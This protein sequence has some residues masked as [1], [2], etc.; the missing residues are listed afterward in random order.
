MA[1]VKTGHWTETSWNTAGV[2]P[3]C[4]ARGCNRGPSVSNR[5][6][7]IRLQRR[8]FSREDVHRVSREGTRDGSGYSTRP[9]FCLD[10]ANG[11][12]D[13]GYEQNRVRKS[14]CRSQCERPRVGLGPILDCAPL[15][16]ALSLSGRGRPVSDCRRRHFV[17]KSRGNAYHIRDLLAPVLQ[18]SSLAIV[19]S[20]RQSTWQYHR[21]RC[22]HFDSQ[23]CWT[24][25]EDE[26]GFK[27]HTQSGH[28]LRQI[29]S[30][31]G[32]LADTWPTF[33]ASFDMTLSNALLGGT[34]HPSLCMSSHLDVA[35]MH[36]WHETKGNQL[37]QRLCRVLLR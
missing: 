5:P 6:A 12:I 23:V 9:T 31:V 24:Q 8:A 16:F 4:S 36:I 34:F 32:T 27:C 2:P 14:R 20:E 17:S 1:G 22:R 33:R 10:I 15:P 26:H 35:T 18:H 19:Q 21:R 25:H 29:G 30:L 37:E 7:R 13:A 3:R 11:A 28:H